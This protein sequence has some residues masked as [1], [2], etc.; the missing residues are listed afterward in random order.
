MEAAIFSP[1]ARMIERSRGWLGQL[2]ILLVTSGVLQTVA[3]EGRLAGQLWE[4]RNEFL[5][6][7]DSD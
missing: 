4:D 1:D 2:Y 5:S 6:Q 3:S 7:G